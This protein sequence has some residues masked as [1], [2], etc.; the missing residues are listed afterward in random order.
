M[1]PASPC[2]RTR[3]ALA[4]DVADVLALVVADVLA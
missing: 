1:A 4:V 2:R 3:F